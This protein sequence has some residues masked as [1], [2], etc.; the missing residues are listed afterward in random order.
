M[1]RSKPRNPI[2]FICLKAANV[3]LVTYSTI[4]ISVLH[5][6]NNQKKKEEKKRK[7]REENSNRLLA[8]NL[9]V[10]K[11]NSKTSNGSK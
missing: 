9:P 5:S 11:S 7:K 4:I 8:E 1:D 2:A 6:D 10:K 3:E